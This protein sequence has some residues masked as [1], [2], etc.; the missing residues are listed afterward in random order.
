[1][2]TKSSINYKITNLLSENLPDD[3]QVG[4]ATNLSE[5]LISE[6]LDK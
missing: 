6:Y 5:V 1:M 3:S 2:S 4:K